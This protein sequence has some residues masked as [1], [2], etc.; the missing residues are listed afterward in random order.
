[1]GNEQGKEKGAKKGGKD[2]PPAATVDDDDDD[3]DDE[4]EIAFEEEEPSEDVKQALA[5]LD[6]D[7]GEG[8]HDGGGTPTHK[9]ASRSPAGDNKLN[10]TASS[11]KLPKTASS[12]KL[13]TSRRASAAPRPA[14]KVGSSG[15]VMKQYCKTHGLTSLS[16]VDLVDL[17]T[18]LENDQPTLLAPILQRCRLTP[19][20]KP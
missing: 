12:N 16:Y 19:A 20:S 9:P 17:R 15:D 10:R 3:E 6:G 4:D 7:G 2:T 14:A 18:A 13:K 8:G 11:N 5:E 1:M